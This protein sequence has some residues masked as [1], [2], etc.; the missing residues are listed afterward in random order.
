M[1]NKQTARQRNQAQAAQTSKPTSTQATDA[2]ELYRI[3]QSMNENEVQGLTVE[4]VEEISPIDAFTLAAYGTKLVDQSANVNKIV[5]RMNVYMGK[6]NSRTPISSAKE[7]AENQV[8][9]LNTFM[10]ALSYE[11]SDMLRSVDLILFLIHAN[12]NDSFRDDMVYRFIPFIQRQATDVNTFTKVLEIFLKLSNPAT[13]AI[14]A[15]DGSIKK[16]LTL[17]DP[18]YKQVTFAL[19]TYLSQYTT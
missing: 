4:A 10:R 1:S 6:M 15:G 2:D 3:A 17:I 5:E 13:R 7:G 8:Y 18:S 12:R 19:V 9:L 11:G 16:A 14:Q